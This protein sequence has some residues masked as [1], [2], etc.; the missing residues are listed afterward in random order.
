MTKSSAK[1]AGSAPKAENKTFVLFGA[2]DHGKPR[3]ATFTGA[4]PA[5]LAKAAEVMVLRL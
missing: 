3:A 4:D 2:D 1:P 5:L